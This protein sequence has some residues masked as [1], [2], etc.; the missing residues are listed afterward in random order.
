MR[1]RI[2]YLLVVL[3]AAT[4]GVAALGGGGPGGGDDPGDDTLKITLKPL[5]EDSKTYGWVRIT[6]DQFSLGGNRLERKNYY[7]IYLVTGDEKMA[8]GEKSVRRTSSSGELKFKHRLEEPLGGKWDKI[9]V[10]HQ[11]N[12]EKDNSGMVPVLEGSLR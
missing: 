5:E 10:Y 8:L 1:H 7:G 12:G 9:V 6:T 11:P 2:A 3:L 4:L